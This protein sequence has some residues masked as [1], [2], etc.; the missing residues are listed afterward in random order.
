MEVIGVEREMP[1]LVEVDA[2]LRCSSLYESL[3]TS[4][5]SEGNTTYGSRIMRTKLI[6]SL[7]FIFFGVRTKGK[8]PSNHEHHSG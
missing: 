3:L 4:K 8:A 2:V 6:D 1:L 5:F 7:V